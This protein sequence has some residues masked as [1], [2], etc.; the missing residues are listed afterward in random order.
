MRTSSAGTRMSPREEVSYLITEEKL[1]KFIHSLEPDRS[2]ALEKIRREASAAA[3]PIIRDETAALLKC[4][5]RM[6]KPKRILEIGTAVGYSALTMAECMP[7]DGALWTIENYPERI[8]RARRNF[9]ETGYGSRIHLLE[10]DAGG[11]IRSYAEQ[12]EKF[13]LIFLDAAKAQYPLWLP[14][15]LRLLPAGGVLLSDNVLQ[16]GSIAE[17]RFQIERRERT[18]HSR[19]REYLFRLKHEESLESAVIPIGDGLSVSVKK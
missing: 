9:T 16:G 17:S 7:S 3:V 13:D 2:P 1:V 15:L 6:K 19:M 5:I 4:F 18:I 14:E 11:W 8:M 12:G 10:G